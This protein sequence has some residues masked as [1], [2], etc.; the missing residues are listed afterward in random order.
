M[1]FKDS[2]TKEKR[3]V[4]PG[5][6]LLAKSSL[7]WSFHNSPLSSATLCLSDLDFPVQNGPRFWVKSRQEMRMDTV[8][9]GL[10]NPLG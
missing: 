2:C 7:E 10:R 5:R 3:W 4:F 8:Y 1:I 6:A 9:I